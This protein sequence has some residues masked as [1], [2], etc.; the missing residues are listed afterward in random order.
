MI[1]EM[2]LC[3]NN[4]RQFER[5]EMWM[6]V[7][8]GPIGNIVFSNGSDLRLLHSECIAIGQWTTIMHRNW[9]Q[10]SW[11]NGQWS[12][13]SLHVWSVYSNLKSTAQLVGFYLENPETHLQIMCNVHTAVSHRPYMDPLRVS[14]REIFF[15]L[16]LVAPPQRAER[17][18]WSLWCTCGRMYCFM[19]AC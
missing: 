13:T 7:S 2:I 17:L 3:C 5:L 14:S 6:E 1:F 15:T 9:P 4:F 8:N 16:F 10:F 19:V 12:F 11:V 18:I